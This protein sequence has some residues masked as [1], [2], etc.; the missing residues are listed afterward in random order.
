MPLLWFAALQSPTDHLLLHSTMKIL[1]PCVAPRR[2]RKS[3]RV[4]EGN[5]PLRR[6]QR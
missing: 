2:Q 5:G 1:Y 3:V 4:C 6:S